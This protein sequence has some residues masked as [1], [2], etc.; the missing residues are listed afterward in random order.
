[1]KVTILFK[2]SNPKSHNGQV[3]ECVSWEV[4]NTYN[5][6]EL[7]F[8]NGGCQQFNLDDIFSFSCD[9]A[10]KQGN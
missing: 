7:V 3:F 4:H 9:Q 1:M 10:Q 6:L 8:A 5:F 2:N